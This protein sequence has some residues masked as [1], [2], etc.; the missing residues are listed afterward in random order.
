MKAGTRSRLILAGFA[1]ISARGELHRFPH[2]LEDSMDHVVYVD[3][4]ARELEKLLVG[5]K[6][7]IVR[8]ATDENSL[9]GMS[10][11]T[12]GCSSSRT[13]AT[14]WCAPAPAGVR[15]SIRKN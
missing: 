12:T 14:A 8:G 10:T 11:R 2:P 1:L 15:S 6:T 9:T 7:M 3:T 4:R 5:E 13:K